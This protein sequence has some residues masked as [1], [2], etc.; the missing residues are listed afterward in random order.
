MIKIVFDFDNKYQKG[1]IQSNYLDDIREHFSVKNENAAISRIRTGN[2]YIPS[3]KYV[4]TPAGRFDI[5]L[6][7][8]IKKYILSLQIPNEIIITDDFNKLI[9][10]NLQSKE[11]VKLDYDLRDYQED[12][13]NLALQKGNGI[14]VCGTG[15]GKTLIMASL[16]NSINHIHNFKTLIIVPSLQ[17]TQQTYKEFLKY[18]I[19]VS[20]ISIYT[21]DNELQNTQIIIANSNILV[22]KGR[23]N[24]FLKDIKL[25]LVDEVHQ[26]RKDN[27][28]NNIIE[29][30]DTRYKFGFTG[31]MPENKIDQWNIIGKIGPI[32]YERS[33]SELR[34]T[35]YL[36]NG[37]INVF[38]LHYKNKPIYSQSNIMDPTKQW[39]EENDF[40]YNNQWRNLVISKICNN[41]NKNT[42]IIVDRIIHGEILEKIIKEQ[43]INK[44]VF[45]IRGD[46][47]LDERERIRQL[48]ETSDNVICVA[49]AKIFSTGINIK[50]LPYIIFALAGKA[51]IKIVQSIGRGLRKHENKDKLVI[52]DITDNLKYSEEHLQ[53]RLSIYQNEQI[54]YSCNNLYEK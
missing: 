27:K 32:F 25:L 44:Q 19:D 2:R 1:I 18:G 30:I 53:K 48:M 50:N 17:L 42:L 10:N 21:G 12:A 34:E 31:T 11:I 29:D 5:W 24:S 39:E 51:K 6:F 40:I 45:F 28:L 20:K 49:I 37:L 36:A 4:I 26:L 52:F 15:G 8:E 47:E 41:I 13:V 43:T 9:T 38:K 14:I 33:S 54:K 7:E 35:D 3:R 46:V 23:D 16:I 22:S